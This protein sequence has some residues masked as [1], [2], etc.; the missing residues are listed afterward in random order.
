MREVCAKC[1]PV[2]L[3]V[4]KEVR[5]YERVIGEEEER[6]AFGV[7]VDLSRKTDKALEVESGEDKNKGEDENNKL[8][9]ESKKGVNI[10]I[11]QDAEGNAMMK[12]GE[13]KE[14]GQMWQT[15]REW[16]ARETQES[17]DIVDQVPAAT[18]PTTPQTPMARSIFGSFA[19]L[20]TICG[21]QDQQQL[22]ED[23]DEPFEIWT[24]VDEDPDWEKIDAKD[25]KQ[26]M[27]W[28]ESG[29]WVHV[30]EQ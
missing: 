19:N 16:P 28:K 12:P 27:L 8:I 4:V 13:V 14:E 21:K 6:A 1:R 7:G 18:P 20:F 10:E 5:E 29:D 26:G 25:A 11:G 2:S 9:C 22:E 23:G 17:R 30:N 3:G 24:K 15:V